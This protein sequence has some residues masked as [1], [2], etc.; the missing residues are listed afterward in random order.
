MANI[1]QVEDLLKE[2]QRKQE[3][4]QKTQKATAEVLKKIKAKKK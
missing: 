3:E 4:L 2:L 1:K